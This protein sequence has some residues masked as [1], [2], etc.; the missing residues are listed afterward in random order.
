MAAEKATVVQL[1]SPSWSMTL[2]ACWKKLVAVGSPGVPSSLGSW[3]A[4]T[5]RPTPALM[6][7][8]VASEMLSISAPSLS[9]R[10]ARRITPTRSVSM[11]RS[12]TGSDAALAM[13]AAS[14]VE[15]VNVATVDVVLTD[16]V[17]DPPSRA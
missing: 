1:T 8:S 2:P 9:S 12:R 3:L 5:V 10:A 15:A 11:A 14:S 16:S 13:P 7:V 6:P 4:A 17:R